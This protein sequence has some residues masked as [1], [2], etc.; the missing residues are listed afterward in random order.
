MGREEKGFNLAL[1]T[2]HRTLL[3]MKT[4]WVLMLA[5]GLVSTLLVFAETTVPVQPPNYHAGTPPQQLREQEVLYNEIAKQAAILDR[6]KEFQK[7]TASEQEKE[8][9]RTENFLNAL[10]TR[11]QT[12]FGK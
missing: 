12:N 2:K 6:L 3:S 4:R 8:I 9:K 1:R 10:V 5:L 7:L 11:Y